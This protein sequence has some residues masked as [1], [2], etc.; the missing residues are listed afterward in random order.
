MTTPPYPLLTHRLGTSQ[1]SA[2]FIISPV[3]GG[4][5]ARVTMLRAGNAVWEDL[6]PVHKERPSVLRDAG[7]AKN[8]SGHNGVASSLEPYCGASTCISHMTLEATA[9]C[10]QPSSRDSTLCAK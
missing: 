7:Y 5:P 2:R 1:N 10:S 8:N 9:E 3:L 4:S 6:E